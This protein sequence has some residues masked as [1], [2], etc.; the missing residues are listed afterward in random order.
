MSSGSAYVRIKRDILALAAR[1]PAGYV[2]T[3]KQIA[4]HLKVSPQHIANVVTSLDDADRANVSW[5]RIVADGGA[6]G[7]HANRDEQFQRLTAEGNVLS[8]VGIVQ[9]LAARRVPD[10]AD[11]PPEPRKIEATLKPSRSRGML[12][13]PQSS[14]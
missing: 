9:D 10:I 12:G 8:P 4:Q 13:K 1:V 7:R 5:W 2:V 14:L 3:H 6:I 11:P